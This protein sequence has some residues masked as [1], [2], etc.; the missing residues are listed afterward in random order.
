[1]HL[2]R[3]LVCTNGRDGHHGRVGGGREV[4]QRRLLKPFIYTCPLGIQ[5]IKEPLPQML[6]APVE[7]L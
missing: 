2:M 1:M 3:T 5:S 4:D 7:A 6:F